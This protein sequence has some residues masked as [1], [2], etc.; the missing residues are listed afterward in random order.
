[1]QLGFLLDIHRVEEELAI[2]YHPVPVEQEEEWSRAEH[3]D[4]IDSQLVVHRRRKFE[5][6]GK[7]QL[8]EGPHIE[9]GEGSYWEKY[10]HASS[11]HAGHKGDVE[12]LR[13]FLVDKIAW[14]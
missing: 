9:V 4:C 7:V 1:L 6:I 11:V 8:F 12:E 10:R 2:G 14:S 5:E 13:I 3:F